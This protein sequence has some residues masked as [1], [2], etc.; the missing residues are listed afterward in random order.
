M[1]LS[2]PRTNT[3]PVQRRFE[4]KLAAGSATYYDSEAKQNVTVTGPAGTWE[5][6]A[7]YTADA[8]FK[9]IVLDTL[10]FI[11][12]F[13]EPLNSGIW[14]NEIRSTRDEKLTV[15]TSK[16]VL[17]EGYYADIKGDIAKDGGKFGNSVYIAYQDGGEWK[18]GNLKLIGAGVSAWFDFKEGKY[19]DSDP[20]VSITGWVGKKKGRNEY[21]EPIF[22]SWAVPPAD[23]AEAAELDETLQEFLSSSGSKEEVPVATNGYGD[24]VPL[25]D[26]PPF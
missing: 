22:A 13:N 6:G 25:V 16:G 8:P 12:G 2:K 17:V 11:G 5:N 21:F 4:L 9:F 26:E 19:F 10:S 14:S 1:S 3:S 18:L 24:Q 7:T 23:I 20:G 15:R